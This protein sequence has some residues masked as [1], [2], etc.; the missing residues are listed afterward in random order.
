MPQREGPRLEKVKYAAAEAR[1]RESVLRRERGESWDYEG[2][3]ED[4]TLIRRKRH[5]RGP[6]RLGRVVGYGQEGTA[7]GRGGGYGN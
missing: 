1:I 4:L 7:K 2:R 6:E 5:E 3:D